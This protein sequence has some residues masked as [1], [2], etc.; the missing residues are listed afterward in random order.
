[1]KGL[2][3]HYIKYFCDAV[4]HGSISASAK[5]N[6]VTL[7]AV[8]QGIS[9]LEKSLGIDLVAHHPNR[10]KLTPAGDTIFKKGC[11]LL[12]QVDEFRNS[13]GDEIGT[14]EFASIYSF[15]LAVLPPYLK[16]FT[17]A[18]PHAKVNFQLANNRQIKE[19]LRAGTID[20]GI[21][22]NDQ[23]LNEYD[24]RTIFAGHFE[25][26]VAADATQKLQEKMGF[27]LATYDGNENKAL[28]EAYFRKFGRDLPIKLE[29]S[30]WEAIANLVMEGAGIGYL[31]DYMGRKKE[32]L[33]K[34]CEILDMKRHSYGICTISPRG[35]QLRKSSQLFLAS[36]M[37]DT[38]SPTRI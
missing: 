28:Q 36:F 23:E 20:F 30:S 14:L 3:L 7:S 10:F 38:I 35:M 26:F 11:E 16:S 9:H 12:R 18:Y 37:T 24:S 34:K 1:M 17:A 22:G 13:L 6:F 25:L 5:A 31:P 27:I 29:V 32:L 19:M 21:V 15:G 8:S 2:N 33:M 4:K